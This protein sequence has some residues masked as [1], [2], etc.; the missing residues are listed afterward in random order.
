MNEL[1]LQNWREKLNENWADWDYTINLIDSLLQLQKET[2]IKRIKGEAV[3]TKDIDWLYKNGFVLGAQDGE[4]RN[5]L[6]DDI[7]THLQE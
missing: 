7:L 5:A 2:M 1:N 4:E 3:P 6:I